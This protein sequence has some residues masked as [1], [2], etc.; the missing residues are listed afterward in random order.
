MRVGGAFG[1]A[2]QDGRLQP[3]RQPVYETEWDAIAAQ[4]QKRCE[5]FPLPKGETEV[6]YSVRKARK[7]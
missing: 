5:D 1:K 3:Q 7:V 2:R 4:W 6:I